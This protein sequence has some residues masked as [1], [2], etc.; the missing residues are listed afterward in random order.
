[1]IVSPAP[2]LLHGAPGSPYTRK[3]L[4]VLPFA[5]R[6]GEAQIDVF[7]R[8]F[9]QQVEHFLNAG[10]FGAGRGVRFLRHGV[11]FFLQRAKPGLA[12]GI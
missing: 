11:S 8:V 9:T 5:A 7:D 4:G 1:M 2:I 6:I 10:G 12:G 3:M